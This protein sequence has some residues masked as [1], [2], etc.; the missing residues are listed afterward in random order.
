MKNSKASNFS[1]LGFFLFF[2]P[3]SISISF[4]IMIYD[5]I[6]KT[7]DNI[8]IVVVC[9]LAY[10]IFIALCFTLIDILRRKQMVEEP[11]LEILEAT[12]KIASGDFSVRLVP[13]NSFYKYTAYDLI[14]DNIN[15][16]ASEMSK[17]KVLG[18]DFVSNVSHELKTPLAVIQNYAKALKE[19]RLD[20]KTKE[21][22]LDTLVTTTNKLSNL[23]TNILKLNKLEN[24]TLDITK[25]QINLT[26]VLSE[27]ILQ[28]ESKIEEKNINLDCDLSNIK[29]NSDES[30][31]E[32]IFANLISNAIK[33]SKEKGNIT[34]SLK[35]KGDYALFTIKDDGLGMSQD[36]GSRIFEKFYQGDTSHAAEGNGLGLAL[37]KKVIDI[38]GGEINVSSQENKGSTFSVKLIKE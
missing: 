30:L 18:T 3:L 5:R 1:I 19:E 17:N 32:I 36:T 35:D 29:L 11:T 12:K 26:D 37:V 24:Q 14:M 28:F 38:L 16:V 27:T 21:K 23:I 9:V 8:A 15:T 33:F 6:I 22:Y 31:I 13:K 34:I 25:K 2:L 20:K 10:I 4:G 7:Y